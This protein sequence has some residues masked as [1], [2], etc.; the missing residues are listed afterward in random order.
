VA[1]GVG[2]GRPV[3]SENAGASGDPW[4]A[5]TNVGVLTQTGRT[6]VGV[7]TETMMRLR[8][9]IGSWRHVRVALQADLVRQTDERRT[10]VS[11]LCAGFARDRAGAHRAWFGPTLSER[12]TAERQQQRRLAEE[13]R[14]KAQVAERQQQRRLAEEARAKAQAE[15]A[16][17]KAQAEEARAKA[18]A[19]EARAKAQA[20]EARAK[21][22]AVQ[23]PPATAK[24][25]PKRH[26]PA[27][28]VPASAARPPVAPLSQAK[29][30][31]FKGSK[32]R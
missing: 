13:A 31:P 14:A 21:V 12:Q 25:E 27:K 9:E 24:A 4:E 28:P 6:N 29:R 7:L 10:R 20:A 8:G 11:A 5:R 17:A 19:E 16:R 2:F 26:K 23:Q 30:P 32:K 3:R 1:E 18:Q 15:E 22:Q